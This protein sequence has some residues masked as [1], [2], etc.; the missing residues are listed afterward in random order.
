MCLSLSLHQA[1]TLT[2]VLCLDS[3][4]L[5][6]GL[7]TSLTSITGWWF[8]LL[9]SIII[10][11]QKNCNFASSHQKLHKTAVSEHFRQNSE[12]LSKHKLTVAEKKIKKRMQFLKISHK[13]LWPCQIDHKYCHFLVPSVAF[14]WPCIFY[15]PKTLKKLPENY[16]FS[17]VLL[18]I[19]FWKPNQ[20]WS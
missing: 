10:F 13:K 5:G 12:L 6:L 7:N 4:G 2:L 18:S 8:P 19:S 14:L 9:V 15:A 20:H 16:S 17:S 1:L 11:L 3:Q